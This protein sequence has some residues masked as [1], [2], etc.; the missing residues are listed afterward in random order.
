MPFRF[1][2]LTWQTTGKVGSTF[3]WRKKKNPE[4]TDKEAV[5]YWNQSNDAFLVFDF[6]YHQSLFTMDLM[7]LSIFLLAFVVCSI[8]VFFISVYGTK[9]V[10]FEEN[11]KASQQSAASG[12]K[13][14]GQDSKKKT[15]KVAKTEAESV[16]LLRL[17][18]KNHEL[19]MK[20]LEL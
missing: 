2:D 19:I 5:E 6:F 8:L 9:E 7:A 15:K 18:F 3:F 10:S 11:L 20:V 1:S 12:N 13:K 16:S 4:K 17:C 14:K